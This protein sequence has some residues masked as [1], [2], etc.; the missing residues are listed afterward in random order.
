MLAVRKAVFDR[1]ER[2]LLLYEKNRTR[3]VIIWRVGSSLLH[4]NSPQQ[5][6]FLY[7]VSV[8]L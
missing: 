5:L 6:P 4:V 8:I 3:P 1:D 7:F 2:K